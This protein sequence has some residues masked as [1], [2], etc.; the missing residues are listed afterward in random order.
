MYIN[1]KVVLKVDKEI[2]KIQKSVGVCQGD[3]M[4][5]ALFL[6]LMSAVDETL[7]LEWRKASIEVLTVAH[8]LDDKLDTASEA[9]ILLVEAIVA[10]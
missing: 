8:T 5:P 4:A 9:R 2:A 1:L 7:E 6:F 10:T 3:N